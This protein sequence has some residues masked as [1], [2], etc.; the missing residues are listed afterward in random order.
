[1]GRGF[2]RIAAALAASAGL[3]AN[4]IATDW[5]VVDITPEGIARA[6]A[7]NASGTV[8]GCRMVN[9]TQ[10]VAFVFANRSRADL[11]APAGA[12][13]CAYAVNNSDVIAG[14]VN[15]EIT[16]WQGGTARGLGLQGEVTGISDS[17]VVVGAADGRAI[18]MANGVVTDLGPGRAIGINRS[19]QVAIFSGGKLF[20]YENGSVRDLGSATVGGADGFNDRGEI[21]GGTSFGHG[22]EPYI[23]DGVVR[24]IPGAYSF[25]GAVA[26]NNAGQVLGSGEG[27][28]GFLIEGGQAVALSNLAASSGSGWHH[29]EGKAINDRGWIVGQ[30]G[31]PDFHAFLMMP[32]EA[33][34]PAFSGNPLA[35]PA[36]LTRPLVR[37]R[38][39]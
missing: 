10:S 28:Y 27:V 32:K 30:N 35:R 4:A 15:G 19:G 5:T 26:I 1:M 25:A 7:I 36:A 9:G 31:S 39:P 2:R 11:Q 22:P 33:S 14:T 37:A 3:A 24:Q 13:S 17:G 29:M 23:Y 18:M 21:V 20:M 34:T 12:T 6:L 8:V 38:T 16:V